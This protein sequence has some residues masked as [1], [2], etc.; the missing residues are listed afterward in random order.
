VLLDLQRDFRRT[1]TG[2]KDVI[3]PSVRAAHGPL[4]ARIN[5]Y[6]N[7]VQQSLID[8]LA[9]A[10]P[11]VQRIVGPR[12]FAAL[13]R[14]YAVNHPPDVPQLSLYGAGFAQF[15]AMHERTQDLPYLPDVARLEWARGEAYFATDAPALNPAVLANLA[16]GQLAAVRFAL[17]P[18]ARLVR[19][20]FPIH[21]IWSVNQPE[22]TEV[23]A[24]DMNIPE[25]VLIARPYYEVSVRLVSS[26][27]AA[28]IAACAGGSSLNDATVSALAVDQGFNL[29]DALQQHFTHGSFA[30]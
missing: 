21:R 19:S 17:H 10:F 25:N 18:A 29:Q 27:D 22:V 9:A 2:A 7:T 14:D 1:V 4:A 11:A 6:R 24:V 13:A 5:V 3:A 16:P 8:V 26:A 12:F 28:F 20:S 15:I 23:P 30:A